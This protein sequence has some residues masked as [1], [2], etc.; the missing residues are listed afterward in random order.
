M[1]LI[2]RSELE[3]DTE[4]NYYDDDFVSYSQSQIK[5]APTVKA[6]PINKLRNLVN[7]LQDEKNYAYAN[8]EEYK[9]NVLGCEDT[10]ELPDD[11]YRFGL[12]RAIALLEVLIA[13]SE[14][15]E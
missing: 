13:E 1:E 6:V 2:D 3:R 8:F 7:K 4:W 11:D 9:I 5:S 12:N 15:E 14:V 10:D